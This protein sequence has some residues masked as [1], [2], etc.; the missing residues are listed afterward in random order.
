MNELVGGRKKFEINGRECLKGV[1]IQQRERRANGVPPRVT[2]N[3]INIL[4]T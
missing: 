3:K 1:Y 2:T 4:S